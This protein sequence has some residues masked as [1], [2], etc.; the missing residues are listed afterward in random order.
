[1]FGSWDFEGLMIGVM[2]ICYAG[3]SVCVCLNSFNVTIWSQMQIQVHL[4]KINLVPGAR[5]NFINLETL[6]KQS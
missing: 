6:Q 4:L 5:K 1:M 3:C 2:L